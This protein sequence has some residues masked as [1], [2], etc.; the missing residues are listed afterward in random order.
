MDQLEIKG[1]LLYK[2]N[3]AEGKREQLV[4]LLPKE[5]RMEVID[6]LYDDPTV[7]HLGRRRQWIG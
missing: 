3:V 6:R 2:E 5:Y 7:G 1:G 4:I